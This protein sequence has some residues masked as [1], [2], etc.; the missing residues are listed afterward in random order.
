MKD[1]KGL[2]AGALVVLVVCA[3]SFGFAYWVA[4]S[5]LPDW[6]KFWLLK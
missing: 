6:L 3:L 5:D 1:N 4:A 2:I